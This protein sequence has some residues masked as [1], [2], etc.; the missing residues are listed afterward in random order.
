MDSPRERTARIPSAHPKLVDMAVGGFPAHVF[1][2]EGETRRCCRTDC[3][4]SRRQ[5]TAKLSIPRQCRRWNVSSCWQH[6]KNVTESKS[7]R[8]HSAGR[9]RPKTMKQ[10]MDHPAEARTP[11]AAFRLAAV[12]SGPRFCAEPFSDAF[13]IPL[14]RNRLPLTVTG[15]ENLAGIDPPVIFAANHASDLDAP[16]VFTALPASWRKRIA[17]AIRADYFGSSWKFRLQYLLARSL[18]NAF[19]LPQEMAGTRRA[20]EYIG[21]LVRRGYCPLIF[22]EGRRTRDGK[23]QSFRPGIGMMAVRL[24]VPVVPMYISKECMRC[25]RYMTPGRRPARFASRLESR[26]GSLPILDLKM[27]RRRSAMRSRSWGMR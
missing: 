10:F 5:E 25:I 21:E 18:Y 27:R 15:I 20:I 9:Q 12:I 6:W 11:T 13:A 22:P 16:A 17:P 2:D 3:Q 24:Q 14:F 19:P 8:T 23:L 7:M 26:C 1:N 4:Q